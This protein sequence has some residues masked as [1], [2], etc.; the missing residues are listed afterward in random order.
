MRTCSVTLPVHTRHV[1]GN[2]CM[3]LHTGL[4]TTQAATPRAFVPHLSLLGLPYGA[5][6][7]SK[8]P[9]GTAGRPEVPVTRTTL[10]PFRQRRATGCPSTSPGLPVRGLGVPGLGREVAMQNRRPGAAAQASCW[11]RDG[12][13]PAGSTALG[14]RPSWLQLRVPRFTQAAL[15]FAVCDALCCRW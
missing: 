13:F 10:G 3:L 12:A 11:R 1:H 4:R 14:L 9:S 8:P 15:F 6:G 2:T 7:R 5:R